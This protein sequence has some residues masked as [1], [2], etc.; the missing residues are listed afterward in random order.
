M[1]LIV[2]SEQNQNLVFCYKLAKLTDN[3]FSY[4]QIKNNHL[5]YKIN[6]DGEEHKINIW[7]DPNLV[8]TRENCYILIFSQMDEAEYTKKMTETLDQIFKI[9]PNYRFI[10]CINSVNIVKY[11]MQNPYIYIYPYNDKI[12]NNRIIRKPKL[13]EYINPCACACSTKLFSIAAD[14]TNNDH[15]NNTFT[16]LKKMISEFKKEKEQGFLND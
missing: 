12:N 16:L 5:E 14:L 15:F 6:F 4:Q 10:L 8:F 9:D 3:I 11:K 7:S 2:I 1:N 13:E